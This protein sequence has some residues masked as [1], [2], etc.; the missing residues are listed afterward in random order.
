MEQPVNA[1]SQRSRFSMENRFPYEILSF[2]FTLAAEAADRH[3]CPSKRQCS[4][5]ISHVSR[6]WRQIAL[7][8]P[9][10]WTQLSPSPSPFV[11]TLLARSGQARLDIYFGT[12]SSSYP[13]F[14]AQVLHH[15]PRWKLC[16]L[17]FFEGE[18]W[19]RDIIQALP[20]NLEM[21][22][23][24]RAED[25]ISNLS[26]FNDIDILPSHGFP[27]L[28]ELVLRAV[29]FPIG[30]PIY[31]GL[32]RVSLV[33]TLPPEGAVCSLLR[34]SPHLEELIPCDLPN[35]KF[36]LSE[37]TWPNER[38]LVQLPCLRILQ[39]HLKAADDATRFLIRANVCRFILGEIAAP[40]SLQ[41]HLSAPLGFYKRLSTL[42]PTPAE[43]ESN[44]PNLS[45][46]HTLEIHVRHG[47]I[48]GMGIDLEGRGVNNEA[49]FSFRFDHALAQTLFQDLGRVFPMPTLE[50]VY[51]SL[52]QRADAMSVMAFLARHPTITDLSFHDSIAGP[53]E[54]LLLTSTR[55][56]ICPLLARLTLSN[57]S[58]KADV[59][60]A[61]VKSRTTQ[62]DVEGDGG[63]PLFQNVARLEHI[64][65]CNMPLITKEAILALEE[66]VTVVQF[67]P[68]RD[69]P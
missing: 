17:T 25:M 69:N 58:I 27:Q 1:D 5:A 47:N 35:L 23:L 48:E 3:P 33:S 40:P 50:K 18:S 7:N 43:V 14:L 12:T 19:P 32:K 36:G 26:N 44:L 4:V 64:T 10:L 63:D 52:G 60:I 41:L 55:R 46:V 8:R 11:N 13:K 37:L 15:Q 6:L 21:L 54:A 38:S 31:T 22:R 59:L 61:V 53:I 57:C 28:C 24:E 51:L 20:E 30:S 9:E 42:F 68:P 45:R 39:V 65:T 66:L 2:I 29:R 16:H 49:V 56:V 34:S 62:K 67:E